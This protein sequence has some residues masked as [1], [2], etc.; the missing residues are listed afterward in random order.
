MLLFSFISSV[1]PGVGTTG[2]KFFFGQKWSFR[3]IGHKILL[4]DEINV[5]PLPNVSW[6]F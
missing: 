3:N 5:K 1:F 6:D 2:Y 4:I